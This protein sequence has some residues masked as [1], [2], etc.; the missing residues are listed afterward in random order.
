M[1]KK[2]SKLIVFVL[3]LIV[4]SPL[5]VNYYII[6][7]TKDKIY[8]E[9]NINSNFK[10]GLVLGCSVKKNGEP[11]KMLK[12]R[13]DTVNK[14][15]QDKVI[16]KIIVSG[17]H[18]DDYSEVLVMDEYLKNLGVPSE[19]ILLDKEGYST[20]DSLENYSEKYNKEKVL[21]ITQ[22]YH[23]Y[24]ALFIA[25][26]LGMNAFG[27]SAPKIKYKGYVQREIREILARNKDFVKYNFN[28]V[29][30]NLSK[31]KDFL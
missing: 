7:T 21:I 2:I 5:I 1:I 3:F 26:K 12:D 18:N 28:V 13:L 10:Y 14:M 9:N 29:N 27:V 4:L 6:F 19:D 24:R 17:D 30:N 25:N 23:L 15:Y 31:T 22:E 8:D 20:G 16:K 11:S